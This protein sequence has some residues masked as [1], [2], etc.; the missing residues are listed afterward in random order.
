MPLGRRSVKSAEK[1]YSNIVAPLYLTTK[2]Y[3]SIHQ[4][5]IPMVL[6]V[7]SCCGKNGPLCRYGTNSEP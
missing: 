1:V 4:I 5:M 3:S 7:T 2:I 6:I